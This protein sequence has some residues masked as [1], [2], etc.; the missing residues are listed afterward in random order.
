LTR[1]ADIVDDTEKIRLASQHFLSC[2]VECGRSN[3]RLGGAR[4]QEGGR[5]GGRRGGPVRPSCHREQLGQ[6]LGHRG[7]LFHRPWL[8]AGQL[9]RPVRCAQML[10]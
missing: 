10:L 6:G 3:P 7:R 2:L 1:D 9:G 4:R 8:G 5:E